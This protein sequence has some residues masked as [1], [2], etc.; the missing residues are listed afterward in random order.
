MSSVNKVIL[1]GNVGTNPEIKVFQDGGKIARLPLATSEK[2]KNRNGEEVNSTEWHNL[3]FRGG[4]VGVVE[5]WVHK[6]TKLYVEGSIKTRSWTDQRT[7]ET[8]YTTE[9]FVNNMLMLGSPSGG[10]GQNNGQNGGHASPQANQQIQQPA[11]QYQQPQ[12]NQQQA[13]PR[14]NPPQN[15]QGFTPQN[16]LA[17]YE[18]QEDDLPF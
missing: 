4:I 18:E 5:K 3:I 8:K 14:S 11:Q 10:Q 9:I 17:Q 12:N 13:P 6:G 2:Y 7:S 1:V 15:Q 16:N